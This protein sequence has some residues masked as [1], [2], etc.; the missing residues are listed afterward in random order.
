MIANPILRREL[1]T[2]LR[3]PRVVALALAYLVILAGVIGGMWPVAGV[4][5]QAEQASRSIVL[6][7]AVAQLLLVILSAPAFAATAITAEKE[8]R[9]YELLFATRLRPVDI[10]AGK[11]G[12]SIVCLLVFVALS[13]PFFGCCFF[14][15]AVSGRETVLLYGI[16][17]ASAVFFGLLGLAVSAVARRSSTALLVTY[18]AILLLCAGPWVPAMLLHN[19]VEGAPLVYGCRAFSPLAAVASV[20]VPT[21]RAPPGLAAEALPTAW[22]VYLLF[23]GGGSVGLLLFLVSSAYWPVGSRPRRQVRTIDDPRELWRRKLR[24]PFYLL[25]PMRRRRHIPD[26]MNPVFARELRNKAFGGGLWIFRSAYLCFA[27]SVLLVALVAGQLGRQS[28]DAIRTVAVAFQLGLI[29]LVVPSLTAGAITQERERLNLDLLRLTRVR[30][31]Q[32]LRGKLA[33]A[34]VF[35]VFLVLGFLPLWYAVVSLGTNT[36]GQIARCATVLVATMLLALTTGLVCSA[37]ARRTA[38]ATAAAYGGLFLLTVATL[39]PV[40]LPGRI[41]GTPAEVLYAL[42]PFVAAIQSLTSNVWQRLPDLWE[43]HLQVS[44]GLSLVFL[45]GAWLRLRRLLAPES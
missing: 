12:A 3:S 23:V 32:F 39:V 36:L 40:L 35:L 4:Y 27:G 6:A 37:A 25:D 2:T 34:L 30:A 19:W 8:Q 13:F 42:N 5:S 43:R 21:F 17:A 41:G 38:V 7:F 1:T 16:A 45:A 10:V 18:L 20:V 22:K 29:V 15:G 11:L 28:P 44:L 31:G 24:F 14:L 33:V 9:S 26:W